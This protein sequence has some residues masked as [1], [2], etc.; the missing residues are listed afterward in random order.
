MK[1]SLYKKLVRLARDGD[2]EAV[3][4]VAEIV[5]SLTE[6]APE[7]LPV[8]PEGTAVVSVAG[9]PVVGM[10]AVP[11]NAMVATVPGT[12][13]APVSAAPVAAYASVPAAAVPNAVYGPM[14]AAAVTPAPVA[15]PTVPVAAVPAEAPAADPEKPETGMDCDLAAEILN[16]LDQ[17]IALLTA[18]APA[19]DEDAPH[20]VTRCTPLS[21]SCTYLHHRKASGV[22]RLLVSTVPFPGSR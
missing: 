2:P 15:A 11:A 17:L 18:A 1:K 8:V 5:E 21:R 4:A 6:N 13:A 10:P 19:D 7:A 14:P 16:R 20:T 3:E 22:H 12:S 9:T